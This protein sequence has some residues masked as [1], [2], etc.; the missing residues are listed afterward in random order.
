MLMTDQRRQPCVGGAHSGLNALLSGSDAQWQ[1]IDKH[2]QGP[3]GALTTEQAAHQH[4]TED[5]ILT[6]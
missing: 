4:G 3:L 1:G 2:A 6:P 5:H